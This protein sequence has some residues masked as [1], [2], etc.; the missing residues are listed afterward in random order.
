M[1][2]PLAAAERRHVAV[3]APRERRT[4]LPISAASSG[5]VTLIRTVPL[6]GGFF[7]SDA[8]NFAR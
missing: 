4:R 2:D 6:T 3:I 1:G 8:V 7:P 5:A